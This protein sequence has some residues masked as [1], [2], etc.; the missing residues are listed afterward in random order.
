M[1]YIENVIHHLSPSQ[2][3]ALYLLSKSPKGIISSTNSSKNIGKVGK[4][5]GGVF[6]SLYRHKI[7]GSN[8]II[9]WGKSE[10]GRGLRWKLN[11]KLINK[12]NLKKIISVMLET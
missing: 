11:T 4:A 2:L 1:D 7:N 9:P 6:S 8:I 5:L 10:T 12:N 3:R